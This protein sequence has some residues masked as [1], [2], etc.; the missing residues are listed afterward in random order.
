MCDLGTEST[1]I[2]EEHVKV[3]EI[4]HDEL[5]EFV[6]EIVSGFSVGTVSDLRHFLVSSESSSHSVINS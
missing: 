6:R 1:I 2:H 3:T 4:V 5:F